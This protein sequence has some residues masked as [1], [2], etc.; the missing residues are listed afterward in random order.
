MQTR[1]YT[2]LRGNHERQSRE[3]RHER[4]PGQVQANVQGSQALQQ[5]TSQV[6]HECGAVLE[7]LRVR[8]CQVHH[9]PV[10]I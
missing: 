10:E 3:S 1:S 5:P 2:R 8:R 4:H 6:V 9:V 7:P